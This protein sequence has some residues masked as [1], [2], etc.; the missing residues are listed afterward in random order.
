[1]YSFPPAVENL[2]TH[3]S[4]QSSLFK[5]W[6]LEKDQFFKKTFNG[7]EIPPIKRFG[8]LSDIMLF[9]E[10]DFLQ[11]AVKSISLLIGE[12]VL[13]K[14]PSLLRMQ[15]YGILPYPDFQVYSYTFFRF[16]SVIGE[17][18]PRACT[19]SLLI[20]KNKKNFIYE[21]HKFLQQ[22][23]ND[24]VNS[25]VVHLEQGEWT[26]ENISKAI[27]EKLHGTIFH[28][29]RSLSNLSKTDQ[30]IAPLTSYRTKKIV[31]TGLKHSEINRFLISLK[32]CSAKKQR[33]D[34]ETEIPITRLFETTVLRWDSNED[35]ESYLDNIDLL[36]YF[37][38]G[39]DV[40]KIEEDQI[41]YSKIIEHLG[42]KEIRI[43]I[44]VIIS[45]NGEDIIDSLASHQTIL[46]IKEQFQS[47]TSKHEYQ[48]RF[49]ETD[50]FSPSA[51]LSVFSEGLSL[52]MGTQ[53]DITPILTRFSDKW[54]VPA[55]FLYNQTGLA[56][57]KYISKNLSM[58]Y[59]SP[60]GIELTGTNLVS[61]FD[62][63][64]PLG[65][66]SPNSEISVEMGK[67]YS[68]ILKK[69]NWFIPFYIL[70]FTSR[71][72]SEFDIANLNV[73]GMEL[74]DLFGNKSNISFPYKDH[75]KKTEVW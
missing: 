55:L 63:S 69:I 67:N 33:S 2:D 75:G 73:L 20:D 56:F 44:L 34:I 29:F 71:S 3:L 6:Q 50:K 39:T 66:K 15:F 11:I 25:L 46:R 57:S 68:A 1:M 53:N 10:R 28:F 38:D 5:Q 40:Y 47:F 22:L 27:V 43:P 45:K 59:P 74:I 49:F 4:I 9:T 42:K 8:G 64:K 54:N 23:I 13:D 31:F 52:L 18:I 61:I 41:F 65:H 48:V 72:T 60:Q 36:Y 16:Y 19:F 24:T 51:C 17:N 58:N 32:Q 70:A 37:V 35:G 14:D 26:S 7:P 12:R 21:H 62:I 30:F